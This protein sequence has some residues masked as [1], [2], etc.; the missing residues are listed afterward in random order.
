MRISCGYRTSWRVRRIASPSNE[1]VITTPYKTTTPTSA[2][3][4]TTSSPVCPVFN[5]TMLT[6]L[7]RI[8]RGKRQRYN[9][10]RRHAE[11]KLTLSNLD[12]ASA[13][14]R[15]QLVRDPAPLDAIAKSGVNE[16]HR[17]KK[18]YEGRQEGPRPGVLHTLLLP[19]RQQFRHGLPTKDTLRSRQHG[20][21]KQHKRHGKK[22]LGIGPGQ[23]H[24][25]Q[26]KQ[27]RHAIQHVHRRSREPNVPSIHARDG[28]LTVRELEQIGG[29]GIFQRGR[30]AFRY[31]HDISIRSSKGSRHCPVIADYTDPIRGHMSLVEHHSAYGHATAPAEIMRVLAKH[32]HDAG[33]PSSA[34]G[35]PKAALIRHRPSEGS[36]CGS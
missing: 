25:E 6:S 1:S 35:A 17:I 10:R 15:Q 29:T 14:G 36:G 24:S 3:F 4:Q 32:G 2:Y 22:R 23:C 13:G 27:K 34:E 28:D 33:I 16:V 18:R 30:K 31:K 11:W 19:T 9:F 8:L 7:R 21:Q 26:S 20:Y 12:D 5:G